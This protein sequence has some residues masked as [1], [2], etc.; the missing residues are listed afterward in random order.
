MQLS[1]ELHRLHQMIEKHYK[2]Q[3]QDLQSLFPSELV[4]L[5]ESFL[6]EKKKL[7]FASE[8]LLGVEL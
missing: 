5:D 6:V 4:V 1:N 7:E 2:N 8:C 3:V